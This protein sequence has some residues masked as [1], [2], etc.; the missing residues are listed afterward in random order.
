MV[1]KKTR[2][3]FLHFLNRHMLGLTSGGWQTE[4]I[5][6]GPG[7]HSEMSGVYKEAVNQHHVG[8]HLLFCACLATT[9]AQRGF[10][11]AWK[12]CRPY[13]S[14]PSSVPMKRL[15]PVDGHAN[16]I[17]APPW[18]A[19]HARSLDRSV[20]QGPNNRRFSMFSHT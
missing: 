8:C 16:R 13:I 20:I 7:A 5:E 18:T 17:R 11:R 10:P 12:C 14:Y 19:C 2:H 15:P 6:L 9:S 1:D 3:L 4:P